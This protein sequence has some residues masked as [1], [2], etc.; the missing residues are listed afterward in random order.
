MWEQVAFIKPDVVV[1]GAEFG[2]AVS[3]HE[4]ALLV[5]SAE[6]LSCNQT[7]PENIDCESSGAAWFFVM[8]ENGNT[9]DWKQENYQKSFFP[10]ENTEYGFSVSVFG[11]AAVVGA[12]QEYSCSVENP[13]DLTCASSGSFYFYQA[14]EIRLSG[15]PTSSPSSSPTSSPTSSPISSSSFSSSSPSSS[16]SLLPMIVGVIVG[17]LILSSVLAG[18]IFLFFFINKKKNK[19]KN[20]LH[21]H[22]R[23]SRGGS[24]QRTP[25]GGKEK[26]RGGG[27][28][29]KI[30]LSRPK[31]DYEQIGEGF[32]QEEEGKEKEKENN[33][34]INQYENVNDVLSHNNNNSGY[35]QVDVPMNEGCYDNVDEGLKGFEE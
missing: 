25:R 15:S 3:L 27:E 31:N 16:S 2:R 6:E 12:R 4:K 29:G 22:H 20:S 35:E 14:R 10:H 24:R 23:H 5:G 8:N 33:N 11:S 17:L 26:T 9:S 34:N 7:T 1:D 28:Y 18:I 19:N 32:G 21:H 30:E 13:S